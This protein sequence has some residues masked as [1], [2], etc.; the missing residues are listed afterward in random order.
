MR[1]FSNLGTWELFCML[2]YNCAGGDFALLRCFD[3]RRVQQQEI[4]LTSD[5][6]TLLLTNFTSRTL[7]LI[8]LQ[9][10]PLQPVGY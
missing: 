10:L 8:D 9:E 7:E 6:R 1:L 2:T 3:V 4:R 5:R